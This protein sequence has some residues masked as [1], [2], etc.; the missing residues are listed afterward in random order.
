MA[1]GDVLEALGLDGHQA[2]AV[3]DRLGAL[4]VGLHGDHLDGR[5]DAPDG[6]HQRAVT[7]RRLEHPR[8]DREARDDRVRLD[9]ELGKGVGGGEVALD[10]A[11]SLRQGRRLC[12]PAGRRGERWCRQ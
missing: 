9:D 6:P 3:V 12:G 7:R 10:P 1:S 4:D 5:V 11:L 8:V 2:A